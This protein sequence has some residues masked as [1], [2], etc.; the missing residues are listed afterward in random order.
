MTPRLMLRGWQI[1]D[2]AA[3][4]EIYG[5]TDVARWLSPAM[6]RVADLDAMRAVLERWIDE[7]TRAVPPA[8][9][10]AIQRQSDGRIVGG[11]V[12][13]PLPPRGDDLEIGWQ[14][15]PEMWGKGYATETT[16]GVA[17]WAFTQEF[18]ELFAVVRPGNTRAAAVARRNGMEWVG[19]T[20]KYFGLTLQVYRLRPADLARSLAQAEA[21]QSPRI[22]AE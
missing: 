7:D 19:E 1:D 6:D 22:S 11:V 17:G 5:S 20:D 21:S 2:A 18:D 9:R 13:L 14:L 16:H 12:L 3:A 10:W 8:G 4:L 15:I